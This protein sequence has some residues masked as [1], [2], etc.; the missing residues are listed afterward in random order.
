MAKTARVLV[1]DEEKLIRRRCSEV[2]GNAGCEVSTTDDPAQGLQLIENEQYDFVVVDAESTG[3]NGEAYVRSIRQRAKGASIIVMADRPS[4][5][6]AVRTMKDGAADYLIKP[7]EPTRLLSAVQRGMEQRQHTAP[8]AWLPSAAPEAAPTVKPWTSLGPALLFQDET[9]VQAGQD[10]SQ[11]LGLFL[12]R[13][14]RRSLVVESSA[15]IG[16]RVRAGLPLAH[17]R[18][19][20]GKSRPVLAP[21]DATVLEARDRRMGEAP[22]PVHG[23]W[24]LRLA[25]VHSTLPPTLQRHP[26]VLLD[27]DARARQRHAERLRNLGLTIRSVTAPKEAVHALHCDRCDLL[28]VGAASMGSSGPEQV[29][30]IR[31]VMP[32]TR[33]VVL[34]DSISSWEHQWRGAGIAYYATAPLEDGEL[35][36]LFA[37]L[38]RVRATPF[39]RKVR[40][41]NSTPPWLH[42]IE[43][44]NGRGRRV[45]VMVDGPV[46]P[47]EHGVG[48]HLVNDLL[49]A[50][51]PITTRFGER[52]LRP[53]LLEEGLKEWDRVVVLRPMDSGQ[54][55]GSLVEDAPH[56]MVPGAAGADR[57]TVLGFQDDPEQPGVLDHRDTTGA[58]IARFVHRCIEG[59]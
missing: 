28:V 58:A 13:D 19:P 33:V 29:R 44:T 26:V 49:E 3:V 32:D 52:P 40:P 45:K 1:V 7:F 54:V 30:W 12:S 20:D 10:G 43:T 17:V 36:D 14:K 34:G 16:S 22:I 48:L 51:R 23:D 41:H 8:K 11:R 18:G 46:L 5:D 42:A 55:A 56:P 27:S 21:F 9:W 4:V 31:N 2:L 35:T 57:V 38:F 47:A 39:R 15:A 6:D 37:G 53:A 59:L 50:C 25:P 24:L